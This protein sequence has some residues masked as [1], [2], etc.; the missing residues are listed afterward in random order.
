MPASTLPH[1]RLDAASPRLGRERRTLPDGALTTVHLG[2]FDR[3]AFALS[4][5][6]VDPCS[7]LVE[8][9]AAVGADHAIV[10]GFYMRPGGP[11]SATSGSKGRRFP[12]RPSTRRGTAAG[13]A[14]TP[15]PAPSRCWHGGD[16]GT[17]AR[18]PAASGPML[19]RE[20]VISVHP[21]VDAEGFS[22]GSHQFDSDISAGRYPRRRSAWPGVTWLRSSATGGPTTTP[23]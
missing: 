19:V 18:R 3:D 22:A 17:R 20:G 2:R 16:R 23:G 14:S 9:C 15:T 11:R 7:T 6:P 13:P 4:V 1:P 8:W 5:V 10:G 21:G 12:A